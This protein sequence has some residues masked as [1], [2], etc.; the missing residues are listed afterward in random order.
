MSNDKE[1]STS[2]IILM[3]LG[4]VG[5]L[6]VLTFAGCWAGPQWGVYEQRLAGE[7]ELQKAE[8]SKRVA[9][10]EAQAKKDSAVLLAEAEVSRAEGVARANKIIG[11]SLKGNEA[12]LRYLW[13][14]S[15]ED[16]KNQVIY[17]P[18]E[19]N[20]PILEATRNTPPA[21]PPVTDKK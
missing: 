12:Y 9:V 16:T 4:V 2:T 8:F 5:L 6:G 21:P 1:T 3:I 20:L 14:H 15:M 10:Q 17:V 18:T 13:I 11:D 7:A 19:T